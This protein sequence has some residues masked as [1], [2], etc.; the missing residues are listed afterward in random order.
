LCNIGSLLPLDAA[1]IVAPVGSPLCK[2][3]FSAGYLCRRGDEETISFIGRK[4]VTAL[5]L[6]RRAEF[7]DAPR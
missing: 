7:F 1:T 3:P 6:M 4:F 5:F 2:R